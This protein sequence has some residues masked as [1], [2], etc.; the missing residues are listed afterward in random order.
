MTGVEK[1]EVKKIK[2]LE[3][4]FNLY[5]YSEKPYLKGFIDLNEATYT[6]KEKSSLKLTLKSEFREKEIEISSLDMKWNGSEILGNLKIEKRNKY[7]FIK[8]SMSGDYA[9]FKA[10]IKKKEGEKASSEDF[11]KRLEKFPF[12]AEIDFKINNVVL[13]TFHKIDKVK[14]YLS[15]DSTKKLLFADI[16][17]VHFCGLNL[18]L[19]YERDPQNQYSYLEIMPSKGELLDLFSCL[20]PEEMPKVILEG[21]FELS[22]YFYA[23]GDQ[24]DFMIKSTGEINLKSHNGYLYRAPLIARVLAYISPIDLF[25]GKVPNLENRLLEYDELDFKSFIQDEDLKIDTAFL[26]AIGF[27]MF[28]EGDVN[29]ENKKLYLTFY[30]SPFKTL[31]I[32]IEKVPYL[33]SWILGKPRMLIYFPLQVIGTYEKYNIIPLHPSSIGKGIFTFIFRFFGI[34]ED[35]F[36]K[37][38]EL[39]EF[40]KKEWLLK[41]H[42]KENEKNSTS[43]P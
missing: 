4:I 3:D 9:D 21:P 39:E 16:P 2:G 35:V 27:R 30:V 19:L 25:R 31:D 28:G 14:G 5:L 18:H 13:P 32:L 36:Q 34:S 10:M 24:K 33:G 12:L 23:E 29:L 6:Y 17:E 1:K 7:V 43:S 11:F 42:K 15:L 41:D 26:S 20:Y 8:G 40:K 22:G 37:P 38:P